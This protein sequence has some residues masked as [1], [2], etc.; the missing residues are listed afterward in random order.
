MVRLSPLAAFLSALLT[1]APALAQA[2]TV[3]PVTIELAPR[4]MAT[5]LTVFD[6]GD[7]ETSFQVRAFAWSQND[8]GADRLAATDELL[9]SPPLGTIPA[10]GSQIIRLV[11]RRPPAGREASY[12]V[13]L[14][15]IPPPPAPGTVRV[16]LRL[17]IPVFAEPETRAT[18]HLRWRVDPQGYLIASNDG[19]RHQTVRNIVLRTHAGD[20]LKVEAN[21]SPYVLPGAT[22][23]WR[24]VGLAAASAL[25]TTLR[26]TASTDTGAI[27]QP[28]SVGA[29]R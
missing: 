1:V 18:P 9:V 3:M 20:Q 21:V 29:A 27:G 28:V 25:G 23:R 8:E 22:R 4:Q 2:L 13:L 14:D 12:R 6:R 17:S 5:T 26:L 7:T 11:L 10:G 15:Q 16:A 19:T 24:I